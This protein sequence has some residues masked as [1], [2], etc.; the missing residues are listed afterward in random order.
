M[1]TGRLQ[2]DSVLMHLITRQVVAI[3]LLTGEVNFD[4]LIKKISARFL[5]CEVTWGG[6]WRAWN[7]AF[8][9]N[10]H[11]WVLTSLDISWLNCYKDGD[12]YFPQLEST[13]G[14]R[15][16]FSSLHLLFFI[17]RYQ[18]RLM[19]SYFITSIIM[20]LLRLSYLVSEDSSWC[21][22]YHFGVFSSLF[23]APLFFSLFWNNVFNQFL[24]PKYS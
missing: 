16:V 17:C 4:Q 2:T 15:E 13:G 1:W 24:K 3:G 9:F 18:D 7:S 21:F 12:F 20:F 8:L 22:Q 10:V 5:Y 14:I 23:W 19:D 11:L 6:N